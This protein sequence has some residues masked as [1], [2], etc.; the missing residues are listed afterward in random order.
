MERKKYLVVM[1]AGHGSRM[2]SPLPKQFMTLGGR[3]V[4][5]RTIERFVQACP[6]I[7]V[8][9]V[10]PREYMPRWKN[11]CQENNFYYPQILVEGGITRFHSVR[12]AL[13]KVPDGA[14]VA[15]QDG[16]RPLVT[17]RCSK[18]CPPAAR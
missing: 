5:Q 16:V 14:I 10:L 18:G 2:G 6:D 11:L 7:K 3:P 12:N 17:P 8:V 4:L 1:A 15:I 13:A 9:T